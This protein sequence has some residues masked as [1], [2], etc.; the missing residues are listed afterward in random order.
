MEN[1]PT[2]KQIPTASSETLR[3]KETSKLEWGVELGKMSWDSAQA[4]IKELNAKLPKGSEKRWKLPTK[5]QLMDEFSKN[6]DPKGFKGDRYWTGQQD[7]KRGSRYTPNYYY[8]VR[9]NPSGGLEGFGS[10]DS[11]ECYARPVLDTF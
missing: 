4:K 9:K 10:L 1:D 8:Y 3:S 6:P 7:Y 11:G 2:R 5:D